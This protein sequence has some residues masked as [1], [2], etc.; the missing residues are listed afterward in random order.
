[1]KPVRTWE[2]H[3]PDPI[4][5]EAPLLARPCSINDEIEAIAAHNGG[6]R[7]RY[8]YTA[9]GMILLLQR[10]GQIVVPV[11]MRDGGEWA[12]TIVVGTDIYPRGGYDIMVG[13]DEIE[14]AIEIPI[15]VLEKRP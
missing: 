10:T 15:A 5:A 3:T 14:Q 12:C 11:S 7:R 13:A 8:S 1:M 2:V 9:K 6:Q 4:L